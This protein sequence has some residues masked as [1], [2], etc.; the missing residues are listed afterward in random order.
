MVE[1]L[2]DLVRS[3]TEEEDA[4]VVCAV[5]ISNA[6]A[7]ISAV[8]L[9]ASEVAFDHGPQMSLFCSISGLA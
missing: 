9:A 7:V 8:V 6:D 1:G 3:N 5:V 2:E 4:S